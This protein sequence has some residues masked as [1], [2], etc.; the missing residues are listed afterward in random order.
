ANN[1]RGAG[2]QPTSLANARPGDVVLMQSNGQSHVVLFAAHENG[3]PKFIGSNNVNA[4]GTQRIS[5]GGASGNYHLL[6]P[7]RC[8]GGRVP[9]ARAGRFSP[10]VQ[11]AGWAPRD[12]AGIP[13]GPR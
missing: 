11:A 12:V 7:P 10:R 2:W 6:T 8:P 9:P 3:V 5:W 4:D 1:L 13:A